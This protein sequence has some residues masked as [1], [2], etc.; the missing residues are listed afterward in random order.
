MPRVARRLLIADGRAMLVGDLVLV[1][2]TARARP[3]LEPVNA[4]DF[5]PWAAGL[6]GLAS[7]EP[8]IRLVLV[9]Q[10]AVTAFGALPKAYATRS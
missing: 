10:V 2:G 5:L 3:D 9:R 6:L 7:L 8:V 4:R 1:F